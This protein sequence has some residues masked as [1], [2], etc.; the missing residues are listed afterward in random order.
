MV[1]SV[2]ELDVLI[3]TSQWLHE[4]SWMIDAV[5]L[6]NGQVLRIGEQKARVK[7]AYHEGGIPFDEA[8]LF[9]NRGPDII[10]R[11]GMNIW[12]IECKGMATVRPQTH[13]NNFDRA[14]ASLMSRKCLD[15]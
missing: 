7:Q 3:A 13:K 10:A 4:R 1:A 8:T 6:A 15:I 12:K 9:N 2:S 11:S 5:S 14:L